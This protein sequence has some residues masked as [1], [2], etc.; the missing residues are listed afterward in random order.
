M[1]QALKQ[2]I[3]QDYIASKIYFIRSQKVMLDSDL[4]ELYGVETKVLNQA[5]KRN[6]DRFPEDF[7]FQLTT[8]EIERLNRSQFVT[9]SQKYRDPRF[10]PYAFTEHGTLMLSS[11]LKSP[12]AAEINITIVRTFVKLR[13]ILATHQDVARKLQEHDQHIANL[14]D[15]LEK[16][17]KLDHKNKNQIG[18]IWD[19]KD[20]E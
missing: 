11:V 18:Y 13:E 12:R 10:R 6:I 8:E 4:A 3:P 14:Y 5:V 17:L 19:T 1:A 15:H 7:M 16:I 2:I 20:K 9:G